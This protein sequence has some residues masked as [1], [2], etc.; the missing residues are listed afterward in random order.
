VTAEG[1]AVVRVKIQG[2]N[3]NGIEALYEM[4]LEDRGWRINGVVARPDPGMV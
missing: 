1:H 3:G 4:V 2:A